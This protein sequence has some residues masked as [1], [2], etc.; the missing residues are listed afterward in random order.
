MSKE[1]GRG[2]TNSGPKD[3]DHME[4]VFRSTSSQGILTQDKIEIM[5]QDVAKCPK[6]SISSMWVQIP[7][8]LDS[9]S[10]VSLICYSHFKEHLLP[11]TED[12]T[13]EKSE[14]HILFNLTA[15]NDGQLPMKKYIELDVNF[16]GPKVPNIGFLII[17]EPNRVLDKKLPG[18]IGWNMIWLTYKV[19][20]DKYGEEKF[21]SFQCPVG[22]NPL[23]FSQLC[24]YHYT[25]I[26][27]EHDYGV[28]SV[29]HQTEQNDMSPKKLAHLA[30]KSP[31]IIY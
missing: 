3:A 31:T 6:I 29:Y 12:P 27:R 4:N 5:Q 1:Q 25:E 7:S 26:A 16:L 17:D 18:I 20:T 15:A 8:L 21:N 24:L 13:G 22:V 2:G 11:K 14:A 23:L 9:G 19:F 28:Q 10:E 30:K